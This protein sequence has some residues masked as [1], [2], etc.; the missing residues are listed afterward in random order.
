MVFASELAAQSWDNPADKYSKA[1]EAYDS[2]SCPIAADDI[3]HFV[4]FARDRQRMRGHAFLDHDRF[5]GAQ[6]MYRWRDLEPTE[7]KYDFSRIRSDIDYL[8]AR[9]KRLFV[10]LQDVTFSAKYK[11]V[12][13][14]LLTE[15]FDGGV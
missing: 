10:Q 6:I 7:G 13:D 14:Y 1:Y 4:Y 3:S 12:P 15:R 9:D 2:A 11:P 8:K 5:D